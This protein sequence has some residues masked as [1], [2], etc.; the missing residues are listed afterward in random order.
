M[1]LQWAKRA[2]QHTKTMLPIGSANIDAQVKHTG[3]YSTE[4]VMR[5]RFEPGEWRRG[6]MEQQTVFGIQL[7]LP[8]FVPDKKSPNWHYIPGKRYELSTY[9]W[10][11]NISDMNK[12]AREAGAGNCQE[13][14]AVA[15]SFLDEWAGFLHIFSFVTVPDH[16]FVVINRDTKNDG[17]SSKMW[18]NESILCDAWGS[19]VC[20]H[21]QLLA[22]DDSS[23]MVMGR[24]PD[25]EK[26]LPISGV[27]KWINKHPAEVRHEKWRLYGKILV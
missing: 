12:R 21:A 3:G 19:F 13:H 16:A 1:K 27:K 15:F 24:R 9:D 11:R 4:A 2:L 23:E 10:S 6:R 8:V 7:P 5:A 22:E 17:S 26:D 14:A 20:T 25:I 18:G